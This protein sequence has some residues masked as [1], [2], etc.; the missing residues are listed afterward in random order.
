MI[1]PGRKQHLAGQI[2]GSIKKGVRSAS[3]QCSHHQE[4]STVGHLDHAQLLTYYLLW[5][6]LTN[7]AQK[8]CVIRIIRSINH[9]GFHAPSAIFSWEIYSVTR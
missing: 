4:I 9:N 3:R 6:V 5:N 7:Q 8:G 1:R 2:D